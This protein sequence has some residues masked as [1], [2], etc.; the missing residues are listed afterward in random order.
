[1]RNLAIILIFIFLF[2]FVAVCANA[3]QVNAGVSIGEEGLRGF[4]LAVGDYFRV[5]EREVILIKERRIPDEEIPVALFIAA[6]ARVIPSVVI[7]LRLGGRSWMDITLHFKLNPEIY[8]VPVE[9]EVKGPPYGK[10][11]GYYKNKNRKDWGKIVLSNPEIINLV[12]LRFIS[13]YH[14]FPPEEV[15]RL[16][17]VGK[18]FI[19][20]NDEVKKRKGKEKDLKG[21]DKESREKEKGEG[22]GKGKGK[23]KGNS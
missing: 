23:G 8:H 11:Y 15:I 19:L 22:K 2:I 5:P 16:R 6:R 1:M 21:K 12:N 7:D 17:A 4:Y 14:R 3:Q 13:E 10:A 18:N 9:G 20:I